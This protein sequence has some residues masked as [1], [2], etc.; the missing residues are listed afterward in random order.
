[1]QLMASVTECL[2]CCAMGG[3]K[4]VSRNQARTLFKVGWRF[5]LYNIEDLARRC[6]RDKRR[7]VELVA[8]KSSVRCDAQTIV[9][10]CMKLLCDFKVISFS[11]DIVQV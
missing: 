6:G 2:T 5:H 8:A 3:S 4:C 11:A 1:M 7:Q 9:K 10:T